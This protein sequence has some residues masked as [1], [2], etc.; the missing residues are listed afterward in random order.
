M[1][2]EEICS[3][4]L[5]RSAATGMI[6]TVKEARFTSGRWIIA[7]KE[8][9]N[10]RYSLG[11]LELANK[12]DRFLYHMGGYIL[13]LQHEIDKWGLSDDEILSII[14]NSLRCDFECFKITPY[15]AIEMLQHKNPAINKGSLMD[16]IIL[17]IIHL[18]MYYEEAENK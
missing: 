12:H 8:D 9:R 18:N 4:Q 5:V 14:P 13:N 15:E 6:G 1:T 2:I 16:L 10:G 11:E 7:L 17:C 3:G